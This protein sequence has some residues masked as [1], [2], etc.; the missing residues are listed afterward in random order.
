MFKA[1]NKIFSVVLNLNIRTNEG[2]NL[3]HYNTLVK[4]EKC[5]WV[6]GVD[7]KR[8]TST[9]T[10]QTRVLVNSE[11]SKK[12]KLIRILNFRFYFRN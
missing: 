5:E 1:D 12:M 9:C 2:I 10:I 7:R 6:F 11:K 4:I 3:H 8:K